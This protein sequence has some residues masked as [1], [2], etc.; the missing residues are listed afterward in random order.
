MTD[1]ER[2][3]RRLHAA[4]LGSRVHQDAGRIEALAAGLHRRRRR[5]RNWRL[6]VAGATTGTAALALVVVATLWSRRGGERLATGEPAA[7]AAVA[8]KAPPPLGARGGPRLVDAPATADPPAAPA[9]GSSPAGASPSG[10]ED[11]A[12]DRARARELWAEYLRAPDAHPIIPNVSHAGYRPGDTAGRAAVGPVVNVRAAPFRAAGDGVTDDTEAIRRAIQAAEPAG[13]VVYL[14]NGEYL[15]SN[16]LFVS[17][18][19]TVLRGESRDRTRLVFTRP[20]DV[21]LG[22]SVKNGY[23]RWQWSGGLV[24]F[25]ARSRQPSPAPRGANPTAAD[26]WFAGPEL[27]R[28]T[29]A[30]RRGD[31]TLQVESGAGLRAG[32]LVLIA[33]DDEALPPELRRWPVEVAAV[34]GRRVTLRQP[35]RFDV[36]PAADVRLH[37]TRDADL[38]RNSGIERMT[39]EMKRDRRWES[40]G[41]ADV[42]GWNGVF[43][44][45]A[46]QGFARDL[47]VI[48]GHQAAGTSSSK[49]I[50]LAEIDLR[51]TGVRERAV[52]PRGIA[53]RTS[54]HDVLV[55]RVAIDP[56]YWF[57]LRLEGS[58]LA[59]S[60]V[61]G[62][63]RWIGGPAVDTVLTDVTVVPAVK[64]PVNALPGLRNVAWG[65]RYEGAGW[66]AAP[67]PEPPNLYEAQRQPPR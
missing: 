61:R 66:V 26:G 54:S 33:S 38:V 60:A 3:S 17:G 4:R 14:P 32:A 10:L 20:L 13:G 58:G 55:E 64:D 53:V 30:A 62:P 18:N 12:A 36:G 6:A 25:A 19:N 23:S 31:R 22:P 47:V 2:I 65:V 16:V 52:F 49:N 29:A 11:L 1:D 8:A 67:A 9:A 41:V 24:W 34:E 45:G 51:S 5:R 57:R 40:L 63:L 50:T 44:Q 48:D 59:V 35:L 21:L 42:P 7:A 39:L 27:T 56:R 46:V 15:V 37:A 43:F 28:V